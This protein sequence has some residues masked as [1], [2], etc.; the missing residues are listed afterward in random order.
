MPFAYFARLSRTQ[1]A[2]YLQSD[3]IPALR[4]PRVEELQPLLPRLQ[5]ALQQDDRKTVEQLSRA[6]A[7]GIAEQLSVEPVDVAVLAV[8]PALRYGELHGLYTRDDGRRPR[9][10]VW[11]RTLRHHRVVAYR[12]FVRTLLHEIGHHLDYTYL[13]LA[14]SFHTEGFFKR[15]SSLWHALA[16]TTPASQRRV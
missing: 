6:L 1:R 12:T 8:R 3:A 7:Q 16:G 9:I 13:K 11:M 2:V 5:E 4:L 10:R 14:D 15:E